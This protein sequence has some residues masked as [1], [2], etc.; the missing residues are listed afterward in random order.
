MIY[1]GISLVV[2]GFTLRFC[3]IRSLGEKFSLE[4]KEQSVIVTTGVYKYVRHP[5]YIGSILNIAG[6]SLLYLPVAVTYLAFAF[7]LARAINEEKIL[8]SNEQYKEY[9]KKTRLW[10]GLLKRRHNGR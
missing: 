4:L 8:E 3:A 7:F 6:L 1:L 2:I 9:Q 5:A 10:K